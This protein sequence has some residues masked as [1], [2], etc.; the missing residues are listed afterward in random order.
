MAT[1]DP[2]PDL[3]LVRASDAQRG[4]SAYLQG[5]TREVLAHNPNLLL[6]KHHLPR[7]THVD[8]HQHPQD[9]LVYMISGRL[10]WEVGGQQIVIATGDSI[11][12]R[13]GVAHECWS[14]EDTVSLDIFHPTR[15]DFVNEGH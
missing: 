2:N 12:I 8:R 6:A 15:P 9:Q 1:I 7:G 11:I 3:T 5:V 4:T 10:R 14:E 13:G